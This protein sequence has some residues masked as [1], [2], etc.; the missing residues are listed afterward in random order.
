M[1]TGTDKSYVI[2]TTLDTKYLDLFEET[3]RYSEDPRIRFVGPVYDQELLDG[4]RQNAFAY[5]HGHEVGGTN[6]SLL[7]AM[8][9]TGAVLLNDVSFNREV[10]KDTAFYWTKKNGVL[11]QLIETLETEEIKPLLLQKRVEAQQRIVQDYSW[12][13][14]SER[15]RSVWMD[16]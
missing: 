10:A 15:Y 1:R 13:N 14:I 16:R 9:T 12:R 5:L 4:I 8:A 3:T 2:I 7:E 11:S 6:P